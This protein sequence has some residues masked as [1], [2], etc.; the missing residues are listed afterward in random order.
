MTAATNSEEIFACFELA[1]SPYVDSDALKE[2]YTKLS[3][4]FHPDK[5]SGSDPVEKKSAESRYSQINKAY[6]T[7]RDPKERL[8][9][10]YTITN[11]EP[12]KDIQRVPP[13]TMDL[14]VEVGQLCQKVDAFLKNRAQT[15]SAIS[16]AQMMPQMLELQ[17][18]IQTVEAKIHTMEELAE[19]ELKA[20]DT[21]WKQ[22]NRDLDALEILYRK[23]SYISRWKQYLEERKLALLTN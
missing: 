2:A 3:A 15:T 1:P 4:Q 19:T 18:A 6:Q 9:H 23:Y 8:M 11:G 12:P 20:L 10:L 14:F 21:Q 13:G 22:N 16:K 7:L 5:F 17:E